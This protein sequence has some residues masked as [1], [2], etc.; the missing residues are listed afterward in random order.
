MYHEYKNL[1]KYVSVIAK[2]M[3]EIV[4]NEAIKLIEVWFSEAKIELLSET[5]LVVGG[6]RFTL[7]KDTKGEWYIKY[8]QK[9]DKPTFLAAT[10]ILCSE[11]LV[12]CGQTQ[13]DWVK[14]ADRTRTLR[15]QMRENVES[16]SLNPVET[17]SSQLTEVPDT[18]AT[19]ESRQLGLPNTG[20]NHFPAPPNLQA[21]PEPEPAQPEP[22][23]KERKTRPDKEVAVIKELNQRIDSLTEEVILLCNTVTTLQAN[24]QLPGNNLTQAEDTVF[25][26]IPTELIKTKDGLD[27]VNWLDRLELFEEVDPTLNITDC[28]V[29]TLNNLCLCTLK[30]Y[31]TKSNGKK[32]K[33]VA[34]GE[35][36]LTDECASYLAFS[37]ALN[38]LFTLLGQGRELYRRR[39]D[40]ES[41]PT[42]IKPSIAPIPEPA[43]PPSP[44]I[45][46]PPFIRP[47]TTPPTQVTSITNY[48]NL[49]PKIPIVVGKGT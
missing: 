24:H 29:Q 2:S 46:S 4:V 34:I 42:I 27:Y 3:G 26:A 18:E 16:E 21:V 38:R 6:N 43:S 41:I 12:D 11:K 25:P 32:K 37:R 36:N 49:P 14:I 1:H 19:P 5:E 47:T 48:S 45:T 13:S 7:E 20:S 40:Q 30:G 44:G 33:R 9:G 10:M 31:T 15:E 28:K 22:P 8:H 35:S 17:V 23:P 39:A